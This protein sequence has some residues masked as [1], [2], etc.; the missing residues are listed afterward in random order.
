MSALDRFYRDNKDSVGLLLVALNDSEAD[1]RAFFD[2]GGWNMPVM[3][4]GSGELASQYGVS[5]VPTT[6]FV[7]PQGRIANVK[8]GGATV[9]DLVTLTDTAR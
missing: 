5:G 4:E 9:D 3:I 6:Y 8:I 7:D 2:E 1:I